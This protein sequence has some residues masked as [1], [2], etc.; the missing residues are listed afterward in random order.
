LP[1]IGCLS[2]FSW[3][4]IQAWWLPTLQNLPKRPH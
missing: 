3:S 1:K 2:Q 4:H